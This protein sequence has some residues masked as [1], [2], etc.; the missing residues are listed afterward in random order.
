MASSAAAVP[1]PRE[2]PSMLSARVLVPFLLVSLIWG[3]TWLV[4]KDQISSVPPTWSVSYRFGVA[5][6]GMF[7]L[8]W[9]RGAPLKLGRQ[10]QLIALALGLFQFSA[11][12]NFVYRAEMYITS[13]LLAVLFAMLMVPNAILSR[14]FLG[15]RIAG[16]FILGTAV[17][18]AGIA[19][20]FV[21]EYRAMPADLGD[22]MLG[23]GLALCAILSASVAN[24]MQS[25][26]RVR[27][28][29]ILSLLAWAMLWGALGNAVLGW[30]LY[31]PPVIETR[32]AYIGGI[33]YLGLLGSVVTFPMYFALIRDI[34][35]ARAAYSS[36]LVP[37]VA[38]MLSTVFEGY[39]WSALAAGGAVLGMIGLIIAMRARTPRTPRLTG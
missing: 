14:V 39:V 32:P 27:T 20:L 19:L 29:P 22:V 34:G 38:M 31:G 37:V 35:P 17:A 30:I 26:E 25:A 16:G 9:W 23:L 36:V 7:A 15:Q 5:A 11:N 6:I 3:S 8:A 10:G 2:E 1:E 24:V 13:G 4:I 12:F 21:Q 33:V 28:M 18:L